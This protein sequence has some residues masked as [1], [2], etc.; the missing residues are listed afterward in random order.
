MES[1]EVHRK[2][3][4]ANL[5]EAAHLLTRVAVE[6]PMVEHEALER[7]AV[8]IETEAKRVIGTYDYGWPQLADSTQHDRQQK[9]FAANEPLLR[10]GQ[11]RDSIEHKVGEHE[12]HVGSND[13]RAVWQELGTSRG[14]PP[15]SFLMGAG[16][17]KRR[18]VIEET[19][20]IFSAAINLSE[21]QAY[22][23]FVSGQTRVLGPIKP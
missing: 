11:M 5:E 9:G 4:M 21:S 2:K 16:I 8:V 12:A 23:H 22:G 19:G 17:H 14:I 10:T 13:Q 20:R 7:A 6:M 1:D 3:I 15:R 18:Q